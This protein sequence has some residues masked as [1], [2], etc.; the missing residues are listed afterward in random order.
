MYNYGNVLK[1]TTPALKSGNL[2]PRGS[3]KSRYSNYSA[4]I[5]QVG[6]AVTLAQLQADASGDKSW[7][8]KPAM[9]LIKF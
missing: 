5:S 8:L 3:L 9:K 1:M 6:P 4:V 2:R 7:P